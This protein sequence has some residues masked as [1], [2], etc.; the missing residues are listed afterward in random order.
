MEYCLYLKNKLIGT[1]EY[2]L[3]IKHNLLN[4]MLAKH[5]LLLTIIIILGLV[6]FFKLED[7][8]I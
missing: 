5:K 3:F 6:A 7:V 1:S 4:S 8:I 2:H